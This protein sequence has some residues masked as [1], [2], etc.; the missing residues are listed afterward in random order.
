MNHT[1]LFIA[2]LFTLSLSL[3]PIIPASAVSDRS[4]DAQETA[5]LKRDEKQQVGKEKKQLLAMKLSDNKKKICEKRLSTIQKIMTNAHER[6]ARQLDVFSKISDRTQVFYIEKQYSVATYDDL[7]AAVN[8]K[9][10]AA[11]VAVAMSN[12]TIDQFTCDGDDPLSIKD[13][14]KAQ[15]QDQNAAL[16]AYKTAVKDLIVAIK[17]SKSQAT[18]ETTTAT[19][20]EEQ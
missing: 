16:K 1:K 14:F 2:G 5:Q 4:S 20:Q 3:T 8:D 17:S 9:K 15:I 10:Q 13:L 18:T 11:T 19:N 6:G 7:V 12:E